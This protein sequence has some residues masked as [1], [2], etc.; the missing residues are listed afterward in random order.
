MPIITAIKIHHIDAVYTIAKRQKEKGLSNNE[1][2]Y[3]IFTAKEEGLDSVAK[4][5]YLFFML[6]REFEH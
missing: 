5:L 4:D 2:D 1:M 3:I 6:G